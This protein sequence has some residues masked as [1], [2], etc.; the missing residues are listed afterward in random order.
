VIT[1]P[2]ALLLSEPMHFAMQTRQFRNQGTLDVTS[3]RIWL[4]DP[5]Q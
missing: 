3:T 4:G 1:R 5:V 2:F